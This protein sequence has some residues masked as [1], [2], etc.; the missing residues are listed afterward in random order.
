MLWSP[1]C[2]HFG[3]SSVRSPSTGFV[4]KVLCNRQL[5]VCEHRDTP[6]APEIIQSA[7][8]DVENAPVGKGCSTSGNDRS[9]QDGNHTLA[10]GERIYVVGV[11]IDANVRPADQV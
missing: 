6:Q 2:G 10:A 8:A 1:A 3:D 11:G 5:R 4:R 7:V 9:I